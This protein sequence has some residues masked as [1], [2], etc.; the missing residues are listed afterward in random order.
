MVVNQKDYLRFIN[1]ENRKKVCT[2]CHY[3]NKIKNKYCVSCFVK[4]PKFPNQLSPHYEVQFSN[5]TNGC[6]YFFNN[7]YNTSHWYPI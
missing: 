7:K 6:I 2:Q 3:I 1:E 4:M 5:Y